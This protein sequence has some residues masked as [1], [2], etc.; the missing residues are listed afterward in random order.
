MQALGSKVEVLE[1]CAE[2]DDFVEEEYDV[3]D[4]GMEDEVQR[5]QDDAALATEQEQLR[6]PRLSRRSAAA[7]LG[8]HGRSNLEKT[9][10]GA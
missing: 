6:P 2:G 10:I 4:D 8:N 9:K 3:E 5:L 1:A 7:V